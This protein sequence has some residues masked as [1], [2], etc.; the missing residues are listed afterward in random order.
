[1]LKNWQKIEIIFNLIF[2]IFHSAKGN[3][4]LKPQSET[5][6]SIVPGAILSKILNPTKASFDEKN[7]GPCENQIEND[8]KSNGMVRKA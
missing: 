7:V 2:L 3:A 4:F 8:P 6:A 5:F 1:M